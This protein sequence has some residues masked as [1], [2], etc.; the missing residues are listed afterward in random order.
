MTPTPIPARRPTGQQ[1]AVE[2]FAM[3][4]TLI[5]PTSLGNN[6]YTIRQSSSGSDVDEVLVN[7]VVVAIAPIASL[8]GG[9]LI[10]TGFKR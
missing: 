8:S 3:P 10:G 1:V 4:G 7:N 2:S 6:T 9:I 5:I